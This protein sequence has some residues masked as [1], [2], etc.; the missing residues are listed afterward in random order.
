MLLELLLI[1]RTAGN[2][3]LY[4]TLVIRLTVPLWPQLN[5]SRIQIRRNPAAHR[6]HH[7]L[8][9]N[10]TQAILKVIDD[11][12]RNQLEPLAITD[13]R[14]LLRILGLQLV[15]ASHL[16]ALKQVIHLTIEPLLG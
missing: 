4:R 16:L 3:N 5:N 1:R 13:N 12:F 11:V 8:A 7:A 9:L 6:H 14:F 15:L 2:D 10:H